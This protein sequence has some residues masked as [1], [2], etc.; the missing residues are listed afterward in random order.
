M[1][2]SIYVKFDGRIDRRSPH[3]EGNN[4]DPI[5]RENLLCRDKCLKKVKGTERV[6][7]ASLAGIPAWMARYYTVETGTISPKTFF[8]T[9]D[10]SLYY[11]DDLAKTATQKLVT[12][13]KNVYPKHCFF[14]TGEQVKMYVVDGKNLW[15]YDGNN[16]NLFEKVS[17]ADTSGDSIYPIDCIEHIDRLLL[18]SN[19][20][21]YI[22]KNLYP[23]VFGDSTDCI[24]IIVGSGRGRNLA[25]GKI[26]DKLFIFNTEGIF[27]LSG[28]VISAVATTFE[29]RFVED[30]K[31]VAGR[32]LQKVENSLIFLADDLNLWSFDGNTT[33]KLTHYEKLEDYIN[34]NR[35]ALDK[36]VAT[37][38][39]SYYKLSFVET[40]R[41]NN[42]L[43][44][45]YDAIEKKCD[46]IRGR[47][48][49]CYLKIDSTEEIIYYQFGRSDTQMLMWAEYGYNFDT[50]PINIRLRTRDITPSK[51][52][53][54]RFTA[55][56]P[57]IR[58]TGD[59]NIG[60]EYFLDGMLSN[61]GTGVG[62]NQNLRGKYKG[63]GLIQ[64]GNQGQFIDRV[65]P[66]INYSKGTSVSF[67][68]FD[69]TKD[70]NC[71]IM[72]IGID[73]IDKG[74]KKGKGVGK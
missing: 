39:D 55:F 66:K 63:L 34:P 21:L 14:K 71:E 69:S 17:L 32:T 8:Y 30:R 38:E 42:E 48:V 16:D 26:E 4:E 20:Y 57:E 33:Q 68:I 5:E 12:W 73:Y 6:L 58:P 74:M 22:S 25:M 28:D 31:I 15:R 47:N 53:N 65:R 7:S 43:E 10:G 11:L 36:A 60:F 67:F 13:E 2:N 61:D 41:I 62:W 54:V 27:A 40:G 9:Q 29:L 70:I 35:T 24:Q 52:R 44:I 51:G 50:Q 19:T 1:E 56:K 3:N 37:Y 72:G 46:F 23:E 49:S 18:L 59:R 64:I 45:W